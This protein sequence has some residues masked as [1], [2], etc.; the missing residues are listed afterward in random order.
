MMPSCTI[1]TWRRLK[2]NACN[3]LQVHWSNLW[4][5]LYHSVVHHVINIQLTLFPY[6]RFCALSKLITIINILFSDV[7][8]SSPSQKYGAPSSR[9]AL[10]DQYGAPESYNARSGQGQGYDYSRADFDEQNSVIL[11]FSSI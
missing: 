5:A 9:D 2:T 3:L 7:I 4:V 6:C 1:V 8:R 10:S 11:L